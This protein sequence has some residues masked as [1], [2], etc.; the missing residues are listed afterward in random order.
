MIDRE[1]MAILNADHH[2]GNCKRLKGKLTVN[3]IAN[4][5][6]ILKKV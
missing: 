5:K 1:T 2:N 6:A 4:L 3:V